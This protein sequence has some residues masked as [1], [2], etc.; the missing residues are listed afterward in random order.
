MVKVT[1]IK[2]G[3]N[4]DNQKDGSDKDENNSDNKGDNS[5]K[6]GDSDDDCKFINFDLA[7]ISLFMLL[8]L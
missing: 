6:D 5:D 1:L 8:I 3:N 2:N 4:P 7:I